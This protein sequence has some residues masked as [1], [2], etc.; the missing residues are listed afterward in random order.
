MNFAV[1][2]LFESE[3]KK[4]ENVQNKLEFKSRWTLFSTQWTIGCRL[5][6]AVITKVRA[7]TERLQCL[8]NW[9]FFR[10]ITC[11][12]FHWRAPFTL[13]LN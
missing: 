4:Q 5:P 9:C 8:N 10:P 7:Q 13:T 3:S 11:I 12:V 6:R 2:L 1:F